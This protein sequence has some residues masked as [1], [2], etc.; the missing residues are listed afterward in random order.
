[1]PNLRRSNRV[2]KPT[3]IFKQAIKSLQDEQGSINNNGE[4]NDELE[5]IGDDNKND[6]S[7]DINLKKDKKRKRFLNNKNDTTTKS[8]SRNRKGRSSIGTS[9]NTPINES[10]LQS[11]TPKHE[12]NT[13]GRTNP[14]SKSDSQDDDSSYNDDADKDLNS[15]NDDDDDFNL[16][17]NQDDDSVNVPTKKSSSKKRKRTS[18]S[19]TNNSKKMKRTPQN[20]LDKYGPESERTCPFCN[21]VFSIVTGLAYHV[22]K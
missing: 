17:M 6:S 21:K 16:T 22:G 11:S 20:K 12:Q 19:S 3:Q 14:K 9:V 18:T 13:I 2:A 5:I 8:N 1:M 15:D 10:Q 4:D 7:V